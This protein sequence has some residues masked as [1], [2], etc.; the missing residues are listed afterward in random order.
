ML[1]MAAL[2]IHK[3][4]ELTNTHY[5]RF[6]PIFDSLWRQMRNVMFAQKPPP[7]TRRGRP[8]SIA[9]SIM[10]DG[11]DSYMG[12]IDSRPATP[13]AR[14]RA[15]ATKKVETLAAQVARRFGAHYQ[16]KMTAAQ[17]EEA[18]VDLIVRL[19]DIRANSDPKVFEEL[20][21]ANIMR[22]DELDEE[23]GEPLN[24]DVAVDLQHTEAEKEQPGRASLHRST[25]MSNEPFNTT[26]TPAA[27]SFPSTLSVAPSLPAFMSAYISVARVASSDKL[28]PN[29]PSAAVP[30]TRAY[31]RPSA[32]VENEAF[33]D[34][35]TGVIY[36]VDVAPA[37]ILG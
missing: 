4:E 19:S 1:G 34:F 26:G 30:I 12:D 22:V 3:L 33:A 6:Y 17:T 32:P 14:A 18:L 2:S 9:P 16:R 11:E 25:S 15:T 20:W 7:A 10:T 35:F 28:H 31:H 5:H 8:S 36:R 37:S 23:P 29:T 27:H 21:Q 24:A 13:H